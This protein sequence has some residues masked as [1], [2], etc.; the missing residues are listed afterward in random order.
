MYIC[1]LSLEYYC[2]VSN[3]VRGKSASLTGRRSRTTIEA[4]CEGAHEQTEVSTAERGGIGVSSWQ[5]VTNNTYVC[6]DYV[7]VQVYNMYV[8]VLH[9]VHGISTGK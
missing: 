8:L 3:R 4:R 7:R 1:M 6:T 9:N 5:D 2:A